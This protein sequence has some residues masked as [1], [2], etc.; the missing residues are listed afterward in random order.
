MDLSK[1]GALAVIFNGCNVYAGED[2]KISAE[3]IFWMQALVKYY[4]QNFIRCDG[5]GNP[6]KIVVYEKNY[7]IE[8]YQR[9]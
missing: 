9:I 3:Y 7:L 2:H 5:K 1:T 4:V 8:H 6:N